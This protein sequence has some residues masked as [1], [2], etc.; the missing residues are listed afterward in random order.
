MELRGDND[1]D[2]NPDSSFDA[3]LYRKAQEEARRLG[4]S[5]AELCR[6]GLRQVL[7]PEDGLDRVLRHAGTLSSGDSDASERVDAIVYGRE[8]P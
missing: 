5:V 1:H 2:P 8:E 6:R 7:P 3:E 4:V